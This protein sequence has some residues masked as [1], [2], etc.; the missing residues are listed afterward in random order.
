MKNNS[1]LESGDYILFTDSWHPTINPSSRMPIHHMRYKLLFSERVGILTEVPRRNGGSTLREMLF[2]GLGLEVRELNKPVEWFPWWKSC[3]D[4]QVMCFIKD[5]INAGEASGDSYAKKSYLDFYY[6]YLD[7]SSQNPSYTVGEAINE[8]N[9][10]FCHEMTGI[11]APKLVTYT[12]HSNYARVVSSY[13]IIKNEVYD[14]LDGLLELWARELFGMVGII[15]EYKNKSWRI[16]Y[17]LG[18]RYFT[19]VN[20]LNENDKFRLTSDMVLSLFM[21]RLILPGSVLSCTLECI[22]ACQGSRVFHYG[23]T[24]GCFELLE[25]VVGLSQDEKNRIG[26]FADDTDSWNYAELIKVDGAGYPIHLLDTWNRKIIHGKILE[27]IKE[28]YDSQK[29]IMISLGK[30]DSFEGAIFN[31]R[32]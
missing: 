9:N 13:E 29:T 21:E 15:T 6:R 24:Y 27:L 26:Y 3:N 22:V 30:D 1:F 18:K 20:I 16:R 8:I 25:K 23:N 5:I 31:R 17:S 4:S 14:I 10:D 7:I 19:A 12:K 32:T 11:I 2:S 28:S